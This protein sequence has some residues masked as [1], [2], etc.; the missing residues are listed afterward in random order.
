M[1]IVLLL[2]LFA[3]TAAAAAGV[4]RWL[5]RTVRLKYLLALW[6]LPVVFAGPGLATG[7]TIVPT[8][9]AMMLLP[10]STLH[11]V[12]QHNPNLNDI[13]THIVPWAKAVRMSWKEGSLPWRQRWNGSGMALAAN[14]QSAA[15]SPLTFLM[16]AL[17]LAHAFT[18]A[19]MV[20]LFLALYGAWLWLTELDVSPPSALFGAVCFGLSGVM[21]PWILFPH[22]SVICLWPWALFAIERLREERWRGRC[23]AALTLIFLCWGLGGHPE[24]AMLGGIFV[25]L[26]LVARAVLKDLPGPVALVR[27]VVLCAA[28]AAGFSAFLLLPQA[29]AIS[30]S[31]RVPVAREFR[32]LLPAQ[33]APHGPFW[34]YG[35]VTA[36]FPR[37][38]GDAVDSPMIAGGAGSFPEMALGY[39]GI[40]GWAATLCI[41]RP[42]SRRR[43]SE[44]ALLLPLIAGFGVAVALWPFF[45]FAVRAPVLGMM[46]FLRYFSWVS[47]AGAAI[48]AFELDRLRADWLDQKRISWAFPAILAFLASFGFW[49]Y[50]RFRPE[51]LATGGLASQTEA[52]GAAWITLG[53]AGLVFLVFRARPAKAAAF[54]AALSAVAA[55]DLL[56]QGMRLYKFQP[57]EDL[58]PDTPMLAFLRS[59]PGPFRVVGEA[60]VLFPN[61]SI[62]AGLED[63]R[64]K[65]PV[66][67][68]D[69]IEFLDATCGYPPGEE[70]KQI[71]DIN[72]SAL[73]FLN[74]RFLLSWPGRSSPG[75]KW[76]PVYSGTDGTV[77]ENRD[78]LP[79]LYAPEKITLVSGSG[80]RAGI[81]GNAF[82]LFGAPARSLSAK[83]DWKEH[84]FV[85]GPDEV[86]R[87]GP[88]LISE[89]S[90]S[91]NR[92]SFRARVE[93]PAGAFVAGSL[94]EDGG[95]MAR[96]ERGARIPTAPANGPFLALRLPGGDHRISLIYLP[97][98]FPLGFLISAGMAV[99]LAGAL[100]V[101]AIPRVSS[102]RSASEPAVLPVQAS[103]MRAVWLVVAAASLAVGLWRSRL[104]FRAALHV[105]V[106]PLDYTN[107]RLADLWRFVNDARGRIPAGASFTVLA[108]DR[109]DEM[110]LYMVSLGL[111]DRQVALPSTYFGVQW[112]YGR[113]AKY[114][115]AYG[116]RKP[117]TEGLRL[118]YKSERGAVYE[119]ESR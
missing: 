66:E 30:Q 28:I 97:P 104:P 107:P 6:S 48:A 35:F 81:S 33:A 54:A 108:P 60:T 83:R 85:L 93:N 50:Q 67:R 70:F 79:R 92:V 1:T 65:D 98:G 112:P 77:F 74:V 14:G 21:T 2:L 115:L 114:V 76:R 59:Q 105:P 11:R 63:I 116:G 44:L 46:F 29:I 31:S 56:Y 73:D 119:R 34:R 8:D 106:T 45:E 38:L 47:L 13:S 10:W 3:L 57:S 18:L 102:D 101:K 64:T 41:L 7:R 109:D 78:A 26:W 95:W 100:A 90:E 9:H 71:R 27:R 40:L 117:E 32:D 36:V 88:V 113:D 58:F 16:F 87:N 15:F 22:T 12:P 72:A 25:F 96:D 94:L 19:A 111:L 37:A 42:G 39:F 84:A 118:I 52:F 4:A 20:K 103:S 91:S 43:R 24:S 62:F 5:G 23:A 75:E 89:Y 49:A 55:A 61:S 86:M 80:K 17:P 68:L 99:L 53:A 69:Y 51:H 110:Y 82:S